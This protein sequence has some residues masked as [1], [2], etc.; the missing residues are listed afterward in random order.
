MKILKEVTDYIAEI[1]ANQL[2]CGDEEIGYDFLKMM[3]KK[4]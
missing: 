1:I 4:L 3:R 2:L